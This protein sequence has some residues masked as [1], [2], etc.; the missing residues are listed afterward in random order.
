MDNTTIA[1]IITFLKAD[2]QE[3]GLKLRGIALFGSQLTGTSKNES[4]VDLII[5]SDNFQNK[6]LFERA[7]ITMDTEIKALKKFNIPLDILKMTN[8]EFN[9]GVENKRFYAQLK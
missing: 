8:E 4:D 9:R 2:L 3:K 6:N 1:A 5:V 7:D